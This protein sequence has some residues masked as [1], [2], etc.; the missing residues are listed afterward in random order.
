MTDLE[1]L[2]L[3]EMDPGAGYLEHW[4]DLS[5][6]ER[7]GII[8]FARRVGRLQLTRGLEL[9]KEHAQLRDDWSRDSD[10]GGEFW[11]IDWYAADEAVAKESK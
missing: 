10:E 11:V 6:P 4:E 8:A 9:A 3:Y 5:A 1:I 7:A 2:E